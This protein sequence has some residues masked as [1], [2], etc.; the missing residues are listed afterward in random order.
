MEGLINWLKEKWYAIVAPLV[1]AA[2]VYSFGNSPGIQQLE[3]ITVDWRFD[4]LRDL[5]PEEI[6]DDFFLIN[7][8]QAS[9]DELGGWPWPRNAHGGLILLLEDVELDVLGIDIIFS[10]RREET[11]D[12]Y[13]AD[14]VRTDPE[15]QYLADSLKKT[16]RVVLAGYAQAEGSL[17]DREGRIDLGVTRPLT[18]VEGDTY[19][20]PGT[21]DLNRLLVPLP[22]LRFD[23]LTG[24]TDTA[25]VQSGRDTRR[26]MPMVVRIQNQLYPSFV[27]QML[28][29]H[30]NI[31]LEEVSIVIGESIRIPTAD[32]EQM[33][34]INDRGEL[35]INYRKELEVDGISFSRLAETLY[36][37]K[38][39]GEPLP[40]DFPDLAGK[41]AIMAVTVSGLMDSATTP[42]DSSISPV[43]THFQALNN[44][45]TGDY[46]QLADQN[47]M[48]LYFIL[49]CWLTL[50]PFRTERI[51][52]MI[53][54]P[55]ISI[56]A[57]S[58]ANLYCFNLENLIL[59]YIWPTLG[60]ALVHG[61]SI[62]NNWIQQIYSKQQLKSVFASYIAP[63][64]MDQLLDDP[65]NIKLGGTRK[66]VTIL[67]SD[68]RGF[69]TI[70]ESMDEETLVTQL[71]EYFGEMV[72]A[73]NANNGTLHKYIGD[74][75]MV[76]W[77]DVVSQSKEEDAQNAVHAAL[78]MRRRLVTLNQKWTSE[79]RPE[80]AIGI[81]LNH[82]PVLVGNIGAE[83]RQEFTVI[84]DAVNLASRLEGVT[85]LYHSDLI[86]GG[87]VYQLLED[88]FLCRPMGNLVVKGRTQPEA[89]YEVLEEIDRMEP[90]WDRRWVSTYSDS[91]H[92]FLERKFEEAI[93]GFKICLEQKPDDY[94]TSL[95]LKTSQEY[96]ETPP[97][98]DWDGTVILKT[99]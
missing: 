95:Y 23:A 89:T 34:P 18:D 41:M 85:K 21:D 97:S 12:R 42:L 60:F 79:G 29:R 7:I 3:N 65:D 30:W 84:G 56:V 66:P 69:T 14:T 75:I 59:P 47:Q 96:L 27:L 25:P 35:L 10:D 4:N 94:V 17:I 74:A 61:G 87:S 22:L 83:Q 73:V 6:S 72:D 38:R 88:K 36:A 44:V 16:G 55:I 76:V 31:E 26:Y 52:V 81:G 68:V 70:S 51:L 77:G 63:S 82:G 57:Y 92:L 86:I 32:G 20:V 45:L 64:V 19:Q 54:L 50:L 71:N 78:S 5:F 48:I 46:I 67:F 58:I 90:E 62:M 80:F 24:F 2:V 93:N 13:L 33:I 91:Y 39:E 1:I 99:K 8:D 15:N 9:L 98:E 11:R 53:G 37:H 43:F 49:A 40:D 28:L